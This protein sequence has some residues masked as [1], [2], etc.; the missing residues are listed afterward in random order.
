ML[1]CVLQKDYILVDL[2]IATDISNLNSKKSRAVKDAWPSLRRITV[3][4]NN[5]RAMT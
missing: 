3:H 1:A 5:K 4:Y 2:S